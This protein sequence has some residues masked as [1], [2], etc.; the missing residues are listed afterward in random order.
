MSY[1]GSVYRLKN[2]I[3]DYNGVNQINTV[4]NTSFQILPEMFEESDDYGSTWH[5]FSYFNYWVQDGSPTNCSLTF[6]GSGT[7]TQIYVSA[8]Y[9]SFSFKAN[10]NTLSGSYVLINGYG[11]PNSIGGSNISV[12]AIK[13]ILGE[14]SN[15]VQGL[16]TSSHINQYSP[17]RPNG[18][19]PYRLG[20]FRYY[21]H[22]AQGG[23]NFVTSANT[24][25]PYL[26][27][28][29]VMA[30]ATKNCEPFTNV[31]LDVGSDS[32]TK[33]LTTSCFIDYKSGS[34][35]NNN[36]TSTTQNFVVNASKW[37]G[38]G[39][40]LMAT[41]IITL[42]LAG[43]PLYAGLN[44]LVINGTTT[45]L[46]WNVS[47]HSD[48]GGD[49]LTFLLTNNSTGHSANFYVTTTAGTNNYS[50]LSNLA[51]A[52]SIGD[53]FTVSCSAIGFSISGTLNYDALEI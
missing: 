1:S 32:V 24:T 40:S 20:D 17:H 30:S 50:G 21:T 6:T 47:V 22:T 31:K 25:I 9:A 34:F 35:W 3:I 19:A 11:Y 29:T 26:G 45:R 5:N 12:S 4:Q 52:N 14:S 48:T 28:Y 53:S 44:S 36:F 16:C 42:T 33:D 41:R 10:S 46:N 39:W 49:S 8:T 23:V 51:Y 13:S 38:S 15:T 7:A 18:S 27:Y 37:N 2:I 43:C